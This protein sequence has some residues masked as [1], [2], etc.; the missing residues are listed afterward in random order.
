LTPTRYPCPRCSEPLARFKYRAF[1]L[2][3]ECC[4]HLH[5]YWLDAGEDERILAL[6][7]KTEVAALRKLDAEARWRHF[8]THLRSRSILTYLRKLFSR[9]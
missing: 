5:G 9:S 4:R 1:R 7:R 2:E 8:R 3:L 6:M